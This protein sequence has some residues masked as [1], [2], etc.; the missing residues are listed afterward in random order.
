MEIVLEMLDICKT[1]YGDGVEVKAND[2]INFTLAKGEIHA[3]LGE[4]GAGKSTLV[5]SLFHKP[6]KGTIKIHG[7]M[8]NLKN[9]ITA[10]KYGLG[11]ARQ[12]LSNSL[13]ERHTVAENILRCRPRPPS[14]N[15]QLASP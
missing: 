10:L 14:Q 1:F 4:N 15:F 2:N 9:P 11:I 6:D 13:V 5:D 7:K 12:D 8:V 3:L